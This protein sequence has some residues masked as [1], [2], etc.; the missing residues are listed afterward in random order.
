MNKILYSSIYHKRFSPVVNAFRYKGFQVRI[1]LNDFSVIKGKRFGLNIN[2]MGLFSLYTRDHAYR[3][4]KEEELSVVYRTWAQEKLQQASLQVEGDILLQCIPRILGYTFNPVSFWYCYQGP[5][6]DN[7]L[8]AIICEVNNTFGESHN[9]ILKIDEQESMTLPKEFHVSPF[10][11]REGQ[12]EFSFTNKIS[13]KYFN[14]NE[15]KFIATMD[16]LKERELS[17]K[18]LRRLFFKL[19]LFTFQVTFLIHWQAFKLFM[20]KVKF[21]KKPIPFGKE[22]TYG[23][24]NISI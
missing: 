13:I 9:Y 21:Y 7:Q 16:A 8:K 3:E 14:Q 18:E 17:P 1:N 4:D 23:D 11:P 24:Y 2:R 15:L 6:S 20:K 12:Y 19:P 10:Y 22:D 5:A